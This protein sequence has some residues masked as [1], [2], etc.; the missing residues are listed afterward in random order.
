MAVYNALKHSEIG[1]ITEGVFVR[2]LPLESNAVYVPT[3]CG[4]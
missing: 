3:L 4:R 1:F 2:T